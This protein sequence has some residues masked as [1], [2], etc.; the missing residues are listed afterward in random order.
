MLDIEKL[1]LSLSK[2]ENLV[3][4]FFCILPLPRLW[5]TAV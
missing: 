3:S 5:I 2:N 1:L 4:E